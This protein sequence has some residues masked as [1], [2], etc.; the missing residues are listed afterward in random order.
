MFDP[1]SAFLTAYMEKPQL[2][3]GSPSFDLSQD[4]DSVQL[5]P[6]PDVPYDWEGRLRVI[7][8]VRRRLG[9]P[10]TINLRMLKGV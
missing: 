6:R 1:G 3:A 5:P 9:T 4:I 8:D 2:I 10:G 7:N